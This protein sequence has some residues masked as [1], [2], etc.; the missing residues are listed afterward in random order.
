MK[1]ATKKPRARFIFR[2][3]KGSET[4]YSL[5]AANRHAD[6]FEKEYPGRSFLIEKR[7]GG[8]LEYVR[9]SS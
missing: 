3:L 1:S 4:F 6:W 9:R 2:E 5:K 7:Q 8:Q